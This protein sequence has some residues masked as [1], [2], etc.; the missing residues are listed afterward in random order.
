MQ[1]A[2][3]F[4]TEQWDKLLAL[5]LVSVVQFFEYIA[6]TKQTGQ[7]ISVWFR[8]VLGLMIGISQARLI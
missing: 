2:T 5:A 4:M 6:S 3:E 8:I 1:V 7:D